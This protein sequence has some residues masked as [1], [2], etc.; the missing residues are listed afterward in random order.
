[1]RVHRV[2]VYQQQVTI[3]AAMGV[4]RTFLTLQRSLDCRMV[5]TSSSTSPNMLDE[6]GQMAA[7][8]LW[9]DSN[10]N[11]DVRH[12]I[13]WGGLYYRLKAPSRNIHGRNYTWK[14]ML[15]ARSEDNNAAIVPVAQADFSSPRQSCAVA[16]LC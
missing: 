8:T 15:E 7:A 14:T 6:R 2:Q 5:E 10:P 11:L 13:K 16:A 4:K 9:T 3:G 12:R 1:M